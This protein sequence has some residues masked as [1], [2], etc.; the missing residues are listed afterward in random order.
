LT[1]ASTVLTIDQPSKNYISSL[2][3]RT[4][5]MENLALLTTQLARDYVG[6]KKSP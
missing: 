4:E 2:E 1:G 5:L 3:R 6:V